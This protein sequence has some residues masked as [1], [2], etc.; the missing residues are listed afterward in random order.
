MKRKKK[1]LNK[2]E[3]RKRSHPH[4]QNLRR[5]SPKSKGIM[6]EII[7]TAL[8]IRENR[9]DILKKKMTIYPQIP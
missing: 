5:I 9:V 7:L 2:G 8:K 6:K 1:N 3:K 4:Q